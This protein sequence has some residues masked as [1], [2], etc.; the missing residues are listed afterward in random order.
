MIASRLRRAKAQFVACALGFLAACPTAFAGSI[1]DLDPKQFCP[2]AGG[3]LSDSAKY[4]LVRSLVETYNIPYD[5]VDWNDGGINYDEY[6]GALIALRCNN[7]QMPA[8]TAHQKNACYGST[9]KYDSSGIPTT[10]TAGAIAQS[11]ATLDITTRLQEAQKSP[12]NDF[13]L[14]LSKVTLHFHRLLPEP[15]NIDTA[16]QPLLSLARASGN[17]T[18]T[19]QVLSTDPKYFSISCISKQA[20]NAGGE[21][22]GRT[23]GAGPGSGTPALKSAA[24]SLTDLASNFRLRGKPQDLSIGRD[25]SAFSG[26]SSASIATVNDDI[27]LKNTFDMHAVLGY[28]LPTQEF[29]AALLDSIPF[30]EYDRDYVDGAKAPPNSS[31]V[32]NFIVGLQEA[33][34]TPLAPDIGALIT[35]QPQYVWGLRNNAQI[36]K[37]IFTAQPEALWPFFVPTPIGAPGFDAMV[38]ARGVV[39][40]G[41]VTRRTTDPTLALTNNFTQAGVQTGVA[42]T[43]TDPNSFFN[44]VSIPVD[45]TNLYGFTGQYKGISL[46]SA[47]INYTFPKTKYITIGLS[48][49][50]GRDINTFEKQKLYKVTLGVKY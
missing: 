41:D 14:K 29:G 46:I 27:A 15:S 8:Q 6:A 3:E 2:A 32:D 13:D 9:P 16:R 39:N 23:G 7:P 20:G 49:V 1:N 37:V 38:Y 12:T 22:G 26:V 24:A 19:A 31:N 21:V 42:I 47:A 34:R 43:D 5:I 11:N 28:V 44:G 45:Y 30:L 48:Y 33:Y 4:L 50:D 36:A 18:I 10:L 17:K 25:D 40:V 35:F